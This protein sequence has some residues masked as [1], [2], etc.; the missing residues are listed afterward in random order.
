MTRKD[1]AGLEIR[2][3]TLLQ[4]FIP[5]IGPV[6][7]VYTHSIDVEFD[8]VTCFGQQNRGKSDSQFWAQSF[9][10]LYMF[11]LHSLGAVDLSVKSTFIR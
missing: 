4:V 2:Q 11:L 3:I 6:R 5:F 7:E 10:R 1:N 9:K 8:H